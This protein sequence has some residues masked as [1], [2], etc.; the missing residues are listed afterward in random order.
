MS[1]HAKNIIGHNLPMVKSSSVVEYAHML[2]S[3]GPWS[4]SIRW[5]VACFSGLGLDSLVQHTL[6]SCLL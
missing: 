2:K 1:K 6:I 4:P 5:A 3:C